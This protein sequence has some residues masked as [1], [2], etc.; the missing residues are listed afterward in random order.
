MNSRL[1][2]HIRRVLA[3]K[4]CLQYAHMHIK[5]LDGIIL[6][7]GLGNGRTYD[8]I[9]ELFPERQIYVF[10]RKVRSHPASTPPKDQLVEGDVFDTLPKWSK[11]YFGKVALIHSD[12]GSGD[13][14]NNKKI[15]QFITPFYEKLLRPNGLLLCDQQPV[16]ENEH[17]LHRMPPPS[18][19]A[20]DRYY[21]FKR[22][23]T[24][25]KA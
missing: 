16:L 1:D 18:G 14:E 15:M 8:H 4:Y 23:N 2:S 11:N 25:A 20:E 19:V 21:I 17:C 24:S 13:T 3:Q 7:M 6:E 22:K 12:I 9:C 10:E 5:K